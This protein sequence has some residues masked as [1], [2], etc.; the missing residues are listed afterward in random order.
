MNY[1]NIDDEFTS[2]F[3]QELQ[4]PTRGNYLE[5][6][7]H[8]VIEPYLGED[9][10]EIIKELL[11]PNVPTTF[12]QINEYFKEE[13]G[14]NK[15]SDLEKSSSPEAKSTSA[16]QVLSFNHSKPLK[17]H[18]VSSSNEPLNFNVQCRLDGK[19]FIDQES[20]QNIHNNV[21]VDLFC[22][23][24]NIVSV[25]T[26]I[27]IESEGYVLT[28]SGEKI[29][30]EN[31]EIELT[32]QLVV[33]DKVTREY[34]PADANDNLSINKMD[35]P[36]D[37]NTI[38]MNEKK[39]KIPLNKKLSACWDQLRFTSATANNRHDNDKKSYVLH[40]KIKLLDE[41]DKVIGETEL[42]SN[43]IK[44]R[45][46][47]PY[48]FSKNGDVLVRD[49]TLGNTATR[50][51]TSSSYPEGPVKKLKKS[52]SPV[53][54]PENDM[55]ND[56]TYEY[57]KVDKNYYLPPVDVGYFPHH[58][59]H[60]KQVFKTAQLSPSVKNDPSPLKFYNYFM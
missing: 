32:N 38:Y 54:S 46:R 24:R 4:Q 21:A 33:K 28:E 8:E 17:A 57:F 59:H 47:N 1:N 34:T 43:H 48:F 49:K 44:V 7:D 52:Q 29:K 3:L 53:E 39:G 25:I 56:S 55:K 2:L 37:K 45:G 13:P 51:R 27:E 11:I 20:Y 5:E 9:S 12:V 42:K 26:D 40:L 30:I 23:R 6:S 10:Y 22:Y 35:P 31:I 18:I 36:E 58:V 16:L 15:L 50:R 14:S 60:N 19:F 41:S